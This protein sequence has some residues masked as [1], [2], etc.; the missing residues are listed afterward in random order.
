[1]I[2]N[3]AAMADNDKQLLQILKN[4]LVDLLDSSYN[5][6]IEQIANILQT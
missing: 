6:F 1:M 3:D 5:G 2:I 4:H